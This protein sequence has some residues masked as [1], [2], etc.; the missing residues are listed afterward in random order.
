M[1][2]RYF[3]L[4]D[5]LERRGCGRTDLLDIMSAPTLAKLGKGATVQTDILDKICRKYNCR[6]EDIAEYVPDKNEP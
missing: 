4:W 3:R 1:A 6:L 5:F 2:I